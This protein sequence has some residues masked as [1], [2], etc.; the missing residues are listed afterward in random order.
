MTIDLKSWMKELDGNK[1]LFLYTIPGTH[2]CVTQYVQLPHISKCQDEDIY[3]QLCMGIRALDIRVEP[4]GDELGMV[5]GY[6]KAFIAPS[7]AG[8][9]L[10]LGD[11]LRLVYRFLDENPS[12]TVVFQ[13]KNDSNKER[14]RCFNALFYYYIKGNEEKWFL[15]NRVPTLDEARGKVVLLRR[16]KMD[17]ENSDFNDM[18]TGLDF[19]EWIEQDTAVPE[20]LVLETKSL[21]DAVFIIQDRFKYKP[22]ERW[23]ECLKPFLDSMKPF[24][25]QYVIDYTSTAGGVKGPKYNSAYINPKFM[26]Y[27]LDKDKYYGTIYLDFPFEELTT[28]IIEHNFR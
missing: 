7:R 16:C 18:N 8:R 28:K 14:E 2:D 15:E 26:E 5:H 12:E 1:K 9:Q 4:L 24:D 27:P 25:G 6:A 22:E 11:V 21:D 20:P 3:E 17:E 23:E 19:S 10:E 13:F